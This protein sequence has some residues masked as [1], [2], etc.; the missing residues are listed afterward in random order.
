[1]ELRPTLLSPLCHSHHTQTQTLIYETHT[2]SY[3]KF[4]NYSLRQVL[5][6][7]SEVLIKTSV[8]SSTEKDGSSCLTCLIPEAQRGI[9]GKGSRKFEDKFL[10]NSTCSI[11]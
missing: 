8:L 6:Y 2:H 10:D 4:I 9:L 1:M 11:I 7:N 3:H 5:C